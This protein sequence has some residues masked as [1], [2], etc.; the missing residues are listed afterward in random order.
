M[1][2][3]NLIFLGGMMLILASCSNKV[4][5][6]EQ[7]KKIIYIV[8]SKETIF[9]ADHQAVE[10]SPGSISI[11]CSGSLTPDEDILVHCKLDEEALETYNRNEFGDN[12]DRYFLP[13][14]N[15]R[16]HYENT[17]VTI[18]KGEEYGCMNFVINTAQLNPER[19]YVI[20]V[21]IEDA[22]GYEIDPEQKTII[23][24]IR[25]QNDYAGDYACTYRI[26][27]NQSNSQTKTAMAMTASQIL[28][29]IAWNSND[30][31]FENGHF[32]IQVESDNRITLL[33][34]IQSTVEALE[35]PDGKQ[36]NYYDPVNKAFYLYYRTKDQWDEW[37]IVEETL[38]KM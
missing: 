29:P 4:D 17:D 24:V 32:L 3:I 28:L 16:I 7:Y 1:K 9:Y 37:N 30:A 36:T 18:K 13:I 38:I 10:T 26:I 20:P 22:S 11:Y 8:N 27:G 6:G 33:P 2:K 35:R 21:T 15:D 5:F 25:V 12:K 31:P 14:P 34:Y 23:Y 19:V